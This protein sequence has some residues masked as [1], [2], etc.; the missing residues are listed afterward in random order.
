MTVDGE[1]APSAPAAGRFP[2][3]VKQE[4][5][6]RRDGEGVAFGMENPYMVLRLGGALDLAALQTAG[7]ELVRRHDALRTRFAWTGTRFEQW[8][9]PAAPAALELVTDADG[10]P[11]SSEE[12]ARQLLFERVSAPLDLARGPVM[13]ALLAPLP[14]DVALLALVFSHAICDGW[15]LELALRE[16]GARYAAARGG[17]P[18]APLPAAPRWRDW[19]ES[20]LPYVEGAA[21]RADMEFWR[22]EFAGTWPAPEVVLPAAVLADRE[23]PP[24]RPHA[25]RRFFGEAEAARLEDFAASHRVT[26]FMVVTAAVKR[27]LAELMEGSDVL[28]ASPF[29]GRDAAD[30]HGLLGCLANVV[31]L[32][33]AV[34]RG[35]PLA[36][37]AAT[38]RDT[39][40]RVYGHQRLP[41]SLIVDELAP[42]LNARPPRPPWVFVY[43]EDDRTLLGAFEGLDSEL[44]ELEPLD[45]W[46]LPAICFFWNRRPDGLALELRHQTHVLPPACAEALVEAVAEDFAEALTP[47]T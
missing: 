32:R 20:E 47:R 2:V 18:L 38:V 44:V 23:A 14:G 3:T 31:V 16:L 46:T 4:R 6:L 7:D 37:S 22:S 9:A 28:V 24:G 25:V 26:P 35:E 36:A 30:T 12:A 27:R 17:R 10:R 45:Q 34:T 19:A 13:R 29:A 1:R 21:G 43:Y 41:F 42:E 40:L 39:V 33:S 15:S 11:P 5:H 8:T